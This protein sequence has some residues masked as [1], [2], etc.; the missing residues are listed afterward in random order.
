MKQYVKSEKGYF[1]EILTD[2]T[3]KR[4]SEEEYVK[5]GLKSDIKKKS[6]K[7]LIK[8]GSMSKIIKSNSIK[9]VENIGF[10]KGLRQ[11][12]SGGIYLRPK[13]KDMLDGLYFFLKNMISMKVVSY[14]SLGC[15]AILV[16][17]KDNIEF[18]F[19]HT[20]SSYYEKPMKTILIKLM[21]YSSN[22][23]EATRYVVNTIRKA[24]YEFVSK[25]SF[26]NEINMQNEIYY[27]S[28]NDE[29]ISPAD[30]LCPA[31]IHGEFD[32][33]KYSY[34]KKYIDV[35]YNNINLCEAKTIY[36]EGYY[37]E[38]T[39]DLLYNYCKHKTYKCFMA[40]EFLDNFVTLTDFQNSTNDINLQGKAYRLCLYEAHNLRNYGFE[41]RDLH[42][43]NIFVNMNY[44]YGQFGNIVGF[45][46]RA[47]I[48]DFGRV[49]RFDRFVISNSDLYETLYI[50]DYKRNSLNFANCFII[51]PPKLPGIPLDQFYTSNYTVP[52]NNYKDIIRYFV[53]EIG[54]IHFRR[55]DIAFEIINYLKKKRKI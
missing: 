30:P 18:P 14:T 10:Y 20:R 5:A 47:I 11:K 4:V 7:K 24:D 25:K 21:F 50:G 52:P 48:I 9:Y 45:S 55:K 26:L 37:V 46:G 51:R 13:Y 33:E 27:T 15:I 1:Y 8:R 43:S 42:S 32:D 49:K 12:M 53:T 31:F 41:H 16:T 17:I 39:R 3:K 40:M 44:K 38:N 19:F 28:F 22:I 6:S 36:E 2:G 23:I 34:A 29:N 35:I 54:K